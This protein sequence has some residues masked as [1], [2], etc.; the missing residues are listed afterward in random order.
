MAISEPVR[1]ILE[2]FDGERPGTKAKLASL[3]MH[4]RLAGTGK[5]M[6][7]PVDQGFEHGPA[8]SFAMNP[9][10]YDPQYLFQLAIDARLSALAGPVGLLGACADRLAGEVPIILKASSADSLAQEHDQAVTAT[11][12]DA[13]EL[14]CA[15]IGYTIYPGADRQ[16]E[17]FEEV[18]DGIAEARANGLAAMIWAYPRGG[19]LAHEDETA[20]DIVAYAAHIAA[21]LGAHIIKVK[22][23]TERIAQHEAQDAYAGRNWRSLET[24]VA[25][26]MQAAFAGKRIVVFSGG[27]LADQRELVEQVRAIARGGG[28]GSIVGRNSFQRTHDEALAL[29]DEIAGV[30]GAAEKRVQA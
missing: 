21:L 6:I 19:A 2:G 11:V 3:L 7:L 17:M 29:L 14:G 10:A 26:V 5:L 16:Y 20:L 25:H 24:R 4:G 22:L 13:L 28:H 15:A 8:R 12:R 30:Y 1:R 23:P 18:R 27:P 9:A